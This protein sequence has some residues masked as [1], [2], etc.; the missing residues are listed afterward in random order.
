MALLRALLQKFSANEASELAVSAPQAPRPEP[1]CARHLRPLADRRQLLAVRHRGR[2]YQSLILA[3]DTDR[4]L[5]WLDE[6]FPRAINLEPGDDLTL[7]HHENG[8]LFEFSAPVV[9]WSTPQRTGGLALPFPEQFYMGPRR[10]WP[11]LNVFGWYPISAR[12]GVPGLSPLC[13]EVLNLSAGGMRLGL[14]GDWRPFLHHR[15]ILPLCEFTVAPGLKVRCRVRVCAF[16]LSHRPWRQTRVS[17]AFVDLAG[18][19]QAALAAF[20]VA[21]QSRALA[22]A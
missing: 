2:E 12:L 19:T 6:L 10:R 17:L 1:A 8:Q 21:Q 9:G 14:T 4:Q 7:S 3:L 11:R 5:L 13:G 22:A 20:V 18:E 15:D 16:N